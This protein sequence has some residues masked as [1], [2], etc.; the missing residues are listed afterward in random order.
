MQE[1]DIFEIILSETSIVTLPVVRPETESEITSIS[2]KAKVIFAKGGL[3][4]TDCHQNP[5]GWPSF[6]QK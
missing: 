1:V 4:V 2:F 3:G 5:S 6:V